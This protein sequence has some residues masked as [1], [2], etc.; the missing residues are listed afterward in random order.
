MEHLATEQIRLRGGQIDDKQ[1]EMTEQQ[2]QEQ[3]LSLV[4]AAE[5][6]S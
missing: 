6:Y 2:L 1:Q 5:I 4:C 3:V